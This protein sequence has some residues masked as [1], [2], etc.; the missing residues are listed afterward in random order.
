MRVLVDTAFLLNEFFYRNP[1]FAQVRG[2]QAPT[3]ALEKSW[4]QCHQAMQVLA[5]AAGVRIFVP[6][7]VLFRLVAVLSE[8][9]LPTEQVAEE[10]QYW[11]LNFPVLQVRPEEAD[12]ALDKA[13]AGISAEEALLLH[14]ALKEE[15]TYILSPLPR[16]PQHPALGLF[17]LPVQF[18]PE[19]F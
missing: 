18:L 19:T 12:E 11:R 1:A 7:Y 14:V 4:L 13:Q 16:P 2:G 6:E 9:G 10:W 3:P 5:E 17:K 8:L 15:I